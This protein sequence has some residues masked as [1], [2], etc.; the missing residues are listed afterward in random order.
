[1]HQSSVSYLLRSSTC[2]H[3]QAPLKSHFSPLQDGKGSLSLNKTSD[4]GVLC[5]G[6]H[7]G[8]GEMGAVLTAF[9]GFK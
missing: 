8:G 3:P 7:L 6:S 4:E 9:H 1:M 5:G 2:L